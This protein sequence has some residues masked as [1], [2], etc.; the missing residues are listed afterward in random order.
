[1]TASKRI[2]EYWIENDNLKAKEK[3]LSKMFPQNSLERNENIEKLME[4]LKI[5]RIG[6]EDSVITRKYSFYNE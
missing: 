1:M 4:N 5:I 3:I 6:F 2:M